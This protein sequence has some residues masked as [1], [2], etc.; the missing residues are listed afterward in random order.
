L[1]R[2]ADGEAIWATL[3]PNSERNVAHIAPR[4][5]ALTDTD[6]RDELVTL[7]MAG[8][9]TTETAIAWACDLLAHYPDVATQLR[10]DACG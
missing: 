8:H 10:E 7:L 3:C 9:E 4:G 1:G 6:L 5:V 2:R